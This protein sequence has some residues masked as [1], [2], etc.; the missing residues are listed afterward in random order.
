MV[1][2]GIIE[3]N[4]VPGQ[5]ARPQVQELTYLDP[6]GGSER[7]IIDIGVPMLGGRLGTVRVGMDRSI[8]D[9][10][11]VAGGQFPAPDLRRNRGGSRC[12]RA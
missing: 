12:S 5:A 2:K 4:V 7:A 6:R 3:K 10:A 1:P 8:I 9:T 11:A